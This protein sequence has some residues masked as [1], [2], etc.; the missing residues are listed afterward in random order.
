MIITRNIAQE[1]KIFLTYHEKRTGQYR[2]TSY[3]RESGRK[4][5]EQPDE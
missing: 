3:T 5:R 2:K 4:E 1:S